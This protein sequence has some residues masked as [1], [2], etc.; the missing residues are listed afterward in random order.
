M[1]T[2]R[3]VWDPV[4]PAELL[5]VVRPYVEAHVHRLPRWVHIAVISWDDNGKGA[6]SSRVDYEYRKGMIWFHNGWLLQPEEDRHVAVAH[7]FAHFALDCL[8]QY[9]LRIITLTGV[10]ERTEKHLR[11]ELRLALEQTTVDVTEVLMRCP[12]VIWLPRTATDRIL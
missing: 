1:M 5:P 2:T 12:E 11:E 7:E 3:I 6:M 4:I 9:A 8:H 10:D